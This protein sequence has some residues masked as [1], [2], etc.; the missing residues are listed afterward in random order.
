M[1]GRGPLEM[2][3]EALERC[4]HSRPATLGD[5]LALRCNHELV[6]APVGR[7]RDLAH[8][9][10]LDEP[11]DVVADG[12]RRY[13]R[14]GRQR[15][16][17]DRLERD[18]PAEERE[19]LWR[20]AHCFGPR[21]TLFLLNG[22]PSGGTVTQVDA[23]GA[24]LRVIGT[25]KLSRHV[26]RSPVGRLEQVGGALLISQTEPIPAVRRLASGSGTLTT[27]IR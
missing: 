10:A 11:T 15:A 13:P 5:A 12:R 7:V 1:L 19:E 17:C 25:G 14:L 24:V 8:V 4:D 18:H 2:R 16:W 27:L 20:Y 6:R 23:N 3:L 26:D 9:A 22:S 21:D